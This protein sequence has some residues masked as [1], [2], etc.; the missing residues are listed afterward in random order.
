MLL[1]KKIIMI[2]IF[3]ILFSSIVTAQTCEVSQVRSALKKA[4]FDYLTDPSTAEMPLAKIK[5]LLSFYLGL[6]STQGSVACDAQI[7]GI[8]ADSL[9]I[10]RELPKCSDGTEYGECSSFKSKYC[11]A[12][13]L[14]HRCNYCGCPS[15][16]S[17]STS[18][19]CE[20]VAENI[21][22]SND[23][24]CG[25]PDYIGNHYCSGGN[26]NRNQTSYTCLSPGTAN[27]SCTS[28]TTPQLIDSCG[29]GEECIEGQ[30]ECQV[31]ITCTESWTCGNWSTCA[32]GQQT[33][34]CTDANSC[35]T[36][37]N[38]PIESQSC[39]PN[40]EIIQITTDPAHQEVPVIYGDIIAYLDWRHGGRSIYM[41]DLSTNQ[42]TRISTK[43]QSGWPAIYGNIIVWQ[44]GGF[45]SA[46]I[47]MY[48]IS[49][50]QESLISTGKG[51]PAIYENIIAYSD[52]NAVYIYDI[53]TGEETQIATV[54][55]VWQPDI[56]GD[57]IVWSDWDGSQS[58]I[59]MYDLSTGQETQIT[60]S[61]GSQFE[62]DIYEN[63]MVYTD[64]TKEDGTSGHSGFND[65]YM[66]DLSTSQKTPI[67]TEIGTQELS[68]VYGNLIIWEEWGDLGVNIY[69]Y[70]LS[71]GQETRLTTSPALQQL[72]DIYENKIVWM[73]T[74][75]DYV[76]SDIYM[77]I[78][79]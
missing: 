47:Y 36:T 53:S 27:S 23:L 31:N 66:Y 29:A 9:I 41:Y 6:G 70:D 62:P 52:D 55:N 37:T 33:R 59:F 11:Y 51:G 13:S 25:T 10:S 45:S 14:L 38:K 79:T 40:I 57:K 21:T 48:D 49:T 15:A 73:H 24:D 75:P 26:V 39:G 71:T 61:L 78:I 67:A 56:Y 20:A 74:P 8:V 44:N 28:T 17:C 72:S 63:I 1:N 68:S 5:D 60:T 32:N 54:G 42:E 35:G 58:D 77:A 46:D 7:S 22:C 16:S 76:N 34:T 50:G 65:I 2:G 4:A 30:S 69:M 18:G 43:L 12:G 64:A 3:A 19:K